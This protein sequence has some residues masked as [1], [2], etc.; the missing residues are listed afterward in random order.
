MKLN[1]KTAKALFG[2]GVALLLTCASPASPSGEVAPTTRHK[3]VASY[4]N[5]PLSFEADQ[6]QAD[7]QVKF[8]SRGSGYTLFLTSSEAILALRK[9]SAVS[10]QGSAKADNAAPDWH[11]G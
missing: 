10:D 5:L 2:W 11:Q 9:Q 4:G 8:L 6:G 1:S 7:G 3:I